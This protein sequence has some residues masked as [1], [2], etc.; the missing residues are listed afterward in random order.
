MRRFA[1]LLAAVLLH[2]SA[3]AQTPGAFAPNTNLGSAA[4]NNALANKMDTTAFLTGTLNWT[5]CPSGCTYSSPLDAWNTARK[6]LS[7]GPFASINIQVANGTYT[8]T[9]AFYT[10]S[11]ITSAVHFLGNTSNPSAVVFNF[12]NIVGNN[13]SGF[14]ANKGGQIG[15]SGTPGVDG[16]TIRG[17]GARIDRSTWADQSYGGGAFALGTGSMI[18]FGPHMVVDSFYYSVIADQGGRFVGDGGTFKNA[19]DVNVLAKFGSSVQCQHCTMTTASHIFNDTFGNPQT[20]GYNA[21]AE[22]SASLYVDGSTASD[23]QQAC[24]AS[25]TAATVWA[26]GVTGSHCTYGAASSQQ[27]VIELANSHFFANSSGIYVSTGGGASVDFVEL[28][29]NTFDGLYNDG[30]SV[31]GNAINSH[32]NGGYGVRTQKV[33]R[34]ELYNTLPLLLGNTSGALYTETESGCHETFTVCT[35]AST[36]ITNGP[37]IPGWTAYTLPVISTGPVGLNATAS[38]HAVRPN[39]NT[40]QFSVVVTITGGTGGGSVQVGMPYN[41]VL[42]CVVT[43]R[44]AGSTF[45]ALSG[46]WGANLLNIFNFDSTY[47]VAA[48][49][50]SL[51]M[52]GFCE[53]VPAL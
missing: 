17:N 4:L 51:V 20:L 36:F 47:P 2:A 42:P 21:L 26:H 52:T 12:T 7:V 5:V 1:A 25:H 8:L 49:T 16:I 14:F 34:S 18:Y 3:L 35:K 28:N 13:G 32:N 50:T 48:G 37:G 44:E 30:G 46:I 19:G 22:G 10:K 9:D 15:S 39:A 11:T 53:I 24:F 41:T 33:G 23:A 6:L 38:M 27:A 45:K 40:F 29:L 43:G 31:W